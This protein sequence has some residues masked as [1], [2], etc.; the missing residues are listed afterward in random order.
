MNLKELK[1]KL[2]KALVDM[3]DIADA[4]EKA[5]RGEFS[6][7]ERQ[8][9]T[10]LMEEAKGLR[11]QIKAAEDD[12]ALRKQINELSAGI[13]LLQA[14]PA[15][16][17]RQTARPQAG[18]PGQGKT[19]GQQFIESD[20][21]RAWY[22]NVAPTGHIPDGTK[23]LL[24]PPV[25]YKSLFGRKDLLTGSSDTSAGAFVQT[26][27]T[28]I[29]EPLGRRPLTVRD[30]IASRTTTSDVVE[31]VRQTLKITQAAPVAE[32]N[33]TDYTGA[34]GEVSGQK[35]EGSLGFEKVTA[36]V[37]TLAVWVPATK[38]ALSDVGQLRGIIDQE[39]TD[40]L[41]EDLED[42]IVGGDGTGE[43]FTGIYHTSGVLTQ[44]WDTDILKTARKAITYLRVTGRLAPHGLVDASKRR[45]GR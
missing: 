22:K 29:Y 9:I 18:Q 12:D 28:G 17:G 33:V 6:A 27:Y 26:D 24:S 44:D 19:I 31:F 8:K 25:E 32:A 36:A 23:G 34:T 21:F 39:L 2:R 20:A 37:K 1:E 41:A 38:R 35:P 3:R 30:V 11:A 13:E 16:N 40:D 43:H 4:A 15:G 7:E 14:P 10:G 45:R 5:G 42:E